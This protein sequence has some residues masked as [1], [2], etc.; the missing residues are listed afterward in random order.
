MISHKPESQS[1]TFS[2][3]VT[4]PLFGIY[5]WARTIDIHL[6]GVALFLLS[7]VDIIL[8]VFSL[9]IVFGLVNLNLWSKHVSFHYTLNKVFMN[10]IIKVMFHDHLLKFGRIPEIRTQN[11]RLKRAVL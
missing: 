4:T 6:I 5:G 11:L 3:Y 8:F 2:I 9:S 1:G 7:Y 10:F